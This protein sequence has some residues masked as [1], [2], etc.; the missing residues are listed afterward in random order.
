MSNNITIHLTMHNAPLCV[1]PTFNKLLIL[2]YFSGVNGGAKL[3]K[4]AKLRVGLMSTLLGL[5]N[6]LNPS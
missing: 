2:A 6:A 4:G 5:E 1:P 3:V